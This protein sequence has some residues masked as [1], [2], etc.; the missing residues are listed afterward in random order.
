MVKKKNIF[1]TMYYRLYK[2][3]TPFRVIRN[4][5]LTWRYPW[6]TVH[7]WR[8]GGRYYDSI[9]ATPRDGGWNRAFFWQ[10]MEDIR[11][12]AKKDGVLKTLIRHTLTY[13]RLFLYI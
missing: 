2:I 11:K 10:M 9:W 4:L 3:W 7:N 8:T 5:I 13:N 6:L 1:K 12:A